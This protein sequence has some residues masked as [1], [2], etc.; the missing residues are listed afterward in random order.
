MAINAIC[1]KPKVAGDFECIMC[2]YKCSKSCD[3]KKHLLT[4][5]HKI[6]EK[7]YI[8]GD[9]DDVFSDFDDTCDKKSP[10]KCRC[11]CGKK[12][13]HY[14]SLWRHKKTCTFPGEKKNVVKNQSLVNFMAS[15]PEEKEMTDKDLIKELMKQNSEFKDLIID[16]T[17][18]M[19]EISMKSNAVTHANSHNNSNSHNTNNVN[20]HNKFNLQFFLNETCKD[21]MNLTDFIDSIKV[22]LLDLE[23]TGENGYAAG[24]TN[25]ILRELKELDICK[26]PIHCSDIKREVFHIKNDNEWAKERELLIK[27]IKQTT[28]KSIFLLEAWREKYP[29]CIQY[30]HPKNDQYMKINGEVL[31]PYEDDVELKDFN[32]IIA[33]VAKATMIDKNNN[34]Q[35]N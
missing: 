27:T 20:S 16:Q 2:D 34:G 22:K 21:A 10:K 9:F 29:G 13:S 19:M 4:G 7:C 35:K 3:M 28:R 1:I 12:Y 33:N 17:Q 25:I 30:D 32:K 11:E 14:N 31:G 24:V 23:Y 6:N 8:L 26:R 18:K 15:T 5:K